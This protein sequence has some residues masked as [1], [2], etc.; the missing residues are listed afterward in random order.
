MRKI[1][2][3]YPQHVLAMNEQWAA[4]ASDR[5]R[6]LVELEAKAR[7]IIPKVGHATV[8][9][10]RS[11]VLEGKIPAPGSLKRYDTP[12]VGDKKIGELDWREMLN[13]TKEFQQYRKTT[14]WS[15]D[16]ATWELDTDQEVGIAIIGDWHWGSWGTDYSLIERLTDEI[17]NTPNLYI[18]VVGD[19]EQMAIRLRGVSEVTDN[20]WPPELQH[21]FTESWLK[22]V[23]DKIVCACWDNHSVEREERGS[24]TSVYKWIMS[25]H[26]TYFNGIAHVDVRIGRQMYRFAVSHRFRG[27]SMFNPTHAHGRYIRQEGHDREIVVAGD[28]HEPG[29]MQCI[30]GQRQRTLLNCGSAQVNSGYG[31][32][33]FSLKTAE[34][35]PMVA[36][37]PDIHRVTPYWSVA[38]W[39]R[40]VGHEDQQ[41][42]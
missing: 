7:E 36:L 31:K 42:G 35:F 25:R 9:R 18:I 40:I 11:L 12:H 8:W 1:Q 23:K 26:V 34:V 17:V 27:S 16:Q 30:I 22:T 3:L 2:R 5:S 4:L 37:R 32:R 19:M 15:N 20:M 38:H 21:A 10:A 33:Y 13:A 29:M 24:G 41:E 14:S 6:P 28:T 39:L